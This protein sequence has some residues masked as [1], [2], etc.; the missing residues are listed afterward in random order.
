MNQSPQLLSP[1]EAAKVLSL[2][3]RGL[4]NL[5]AQGSGPAYVRISSR[6]VRYSIEAL[7]RYIEGRTKSCTKEETNLPQSLR[8][9]AS[10]D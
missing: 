1:S 4:E 6:C 7:N 5:R 2:S 10:H 8:R 3:K 9:E